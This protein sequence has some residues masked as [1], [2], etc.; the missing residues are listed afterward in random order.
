M[1]INGIPCIINSSSTSKLQR[2]KLNK[3]EQLL[4]A[5]ILTKFTEDSDNESEHITVNIYLYSK[6]WFNV[7]VTFFIKI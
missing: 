1:T 5:K 7:F 6:V 3:D 2:Y 4:L